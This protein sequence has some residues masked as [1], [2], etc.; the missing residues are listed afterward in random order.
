MICGVRNVHKGVE[1]GTDFETRY[2]TRLPS[3]S[4]YIMVTSGL[5]E[6]GNKNSRGGGEQER[7]SVRRVRGGVS[8]LTLR[9]INHK[10]CCWWCGGFA[11]ALLYLCRI[12]TALASLRAV[13][14]CSSLSTG[15]IRQ[16]IFNFR[17]N[18]SRK[19]ISPKWHTHTD[20]MWVSE[21]GLGKVSCAAKTKPAFLI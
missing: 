8:I 1:T 9:N 10:I 2:F 12:T 5:R 3:K 21:S 13:L 15:D 14:L 11:V 18:L 20:K 6:R 19:H 4:S 17:V 7:E 16:T